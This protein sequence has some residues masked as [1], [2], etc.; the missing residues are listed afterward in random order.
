M[1]RDTQKRL[2][3]FL[4]IAKDVLGFS[5]RY[6]IKALSIIA[7]VEDINHP[8]YLE[9]FNVQ[10]GDPVAILEDGHRQKIETW[11]EQ[12]AQVGA[13][14]N[15]SYARWI[16][17]A[18]AVATAILIA[19]LLF[20]CGSA[21]SWPEQVNL[22]GADARWADPSECQLAANNEY[23]TVTVD[24]TE[25]FCDDAEP[26]AGFPLTVIMYREE[27]TRVERAQKNLTI[28]KR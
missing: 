26:V 6:R 22:Q 2:F 9:T 4:I 19:S 18:V 3:K 1:K 12:A 20:G 13:W 21:H 28:E 25:Y 8:G 24:G 16:T 10:H 5:F 14:T 11:E 27:G 15:R 23:T 7:Q 17:A